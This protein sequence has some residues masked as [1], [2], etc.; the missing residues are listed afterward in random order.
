[1]IP[2][3]L[4]LRRCG[5]FQGDADIAGTDADERMPKGRT[6]WWVRALRFAAILLVAAGVAAGFLAW[7]LSQG[8]LFLPF[9]ASRIEGAVTNAA[10]DVNIE[11]GLAGIE[12]GDDLN[13]ELVVRD[14]RLERP[15]DVAVSVNEMRIA[16]RWPAPTDKHIP[17]DGVVLDHVLVSDIGP[18]VKVPPIDRVVLAVRQAVEENGLDFL[19]IRSFGFGI[20]RPGKMRRD[21]VSD[22]SVTGSVREGHIVEAQAIGLGASGAVSL[23]LTSDLSATDERTVVNLETHGF[24]LA[25]LASAKGR[26]DLNLAGSISLSGAITVAPGKGVTEAGWQVVLGPSLRFGDTEANA[27]AGPVRLDF[28]WDPDKELI[29]LNPSPI[30]LDNG[31]LLA[32]GEVVPPRSDKLWSFDFKFEGQDVLSG[33]RTSDGRIAGSYDQSDEMLVMDDMHVEGAGISFTAAARASHRDGAAFAVLSGVSPRLPLAALKALWPITVAP[34]VRSWI[35]THIHEGLVSNATVDLAMRGDQ[36]GGSGMVAPEAT[37]AFEFSKAVFTPFDDAPM[38]RDAVGRGKL[39]GNRFEIA[40]DS[41]W[42]DL[43]QGRRLDLQPS[44][45]VVPVVNAKVP[46]GEVALRLS[47][48]AAAGVALWNRLPFAE[49]ADFS[50][51]PADVAGEVMADLSIR[52]P[53]AAEIADTDIVYAGR[54]D[55]AGFAPGTPIS[56]R[57]VTRGNLAIEL[58][59]GAAHVSGK[60]LIDD[61]PADVFLTLPLSGDGEA[62]SVVKL[63]LDAAAAKSYGLDLGDMLGGVVAV[64]MTDTGTSRRVSVNLAKADISLP[65]VGFHK[66]AGKPGTLSFDLSSGSAGTTIDNLVLKAGAAEVEGQVKLNGAGDFIG[67]NLTKFN[68][69]TADRMTLKASRGSGGL[70][71]AVSGSRLDARSLVANLLRRT[72]ATGIPGDTALTLSATIANVFGEAGEQL[73]GLNLTAAITDGEIVDLSL[74]VQTSGGGSASATVQPAA[75]GRAIKVEAGEVGRLLRFLGVYR[76]VYGGRA[77]LTGVIDDR[78]ILSAR[79]DGNRWK[80]VAEPALAQLSTASRDGPTEGLSTADIRRLMFDVKFGNGMLSI[81]EGFI[82]TETAGLTMAGDV[83]FSK[84]ALRLA[85]SY[86]PASQLD[87]VLAAIPLLG[88]TIF[89][90]GGR[91]GLL[92]VSYRLSGPIDAPSLS[93]NPLSA[94]APGIF[95]RLFELK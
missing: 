52:L 41:G 13:P 62:K 61:A 18:K 5:L 16:A 19:E 80:V 73:D 20:E 10:P 64:E 69:S 57:S 4:A 63:N 36:P 31:Y 9:L 79:I 8:P 81:G 37:L 38:I 89:A 55:L 50:P 82:R 24:D 12:L 43:G 88:Q 66:P 72:S 47:G 15:N 68:F 45:F 42:V 6:R 2:A 92:G 3:V 1:M 75:T 7:R 59:D 35:G 17:L 67:A 48:S 27:L 44:T 28:S 14:I 54:V 21:V 84:N 91:S 74:T 70:K 95:R 30:I 77:T 87:S 65:L 49:A 90:G 32:H 56:G 40:V 39:T 85:G 83:D 53:L 86:L 78:G 46:D 11:V 94:I 23:R 58:H 34:E 93:V 71:V 60:A 51:D 76:R 26:D 25:D 22:V 33:I 29:S